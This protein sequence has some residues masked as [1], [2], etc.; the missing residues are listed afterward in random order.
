VEKYKDHERPRGKCYDC[1]R[2]YHS[3]PDLII[4]DEMW[5][6]INPTHHEGA[7][8]LCLTCSGIRLREDGLHEVPA[9]FYC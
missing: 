6:K 5:R 2:P 9:T 1:K 3:F 8:L 7:G 4:S